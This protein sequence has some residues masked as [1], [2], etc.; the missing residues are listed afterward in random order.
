MEEIRPMFA[1]L[2]ST[3][4][5]EY[6]RQMQGCADLTPECFHNNV[7]YLPTEKSF[8]ISV[9]RAYELET[10]YELYEELY[11]PIPEKLQRKLSEEERKAWY[12]RMRTAHRKY[13]NV[14]QVREAMPVYPRLSAVYK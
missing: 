7:S 12:E 3:E 9:S 14:F 10:V 5:K 6:Q 11:I 4:Y 13:G 8:W 2:D 1:R